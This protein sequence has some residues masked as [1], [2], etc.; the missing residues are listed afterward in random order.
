MPGPDDDVIDQALGVLMWHHHVDANVAFRWLVL[1][2][3]HRQNSVSQAA[4]A[5]VGVG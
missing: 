2:S 3:E 1:M 4:R 5:V